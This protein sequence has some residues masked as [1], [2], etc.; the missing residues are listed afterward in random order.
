MER[1]R[2]KAEPQAGQTEEGSFE[3]RNGESFF[4]PIRIVSVFTGKGTALKTEVLPLSYTILHAKAILF[5]KETE[6]GEKAQA[7]Q[8]REFWAHTRT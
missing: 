8:K 2:K 4:T 6:N 7:F 3:N 1:H 5:S